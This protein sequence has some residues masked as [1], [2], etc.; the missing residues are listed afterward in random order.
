MGLPAVKKDDKDAESC[1]MM[2]DKKDD[3]KSGD[4]AKP[5]CCDKEETP[6][7]DG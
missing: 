4:K 1:P 7:K 5:S 3:G 6:K 2:K